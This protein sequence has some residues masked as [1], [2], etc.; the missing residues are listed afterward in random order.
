MKEGYLYVATGEQYID[1]A[2][3]SAKSLRKGNK[4]VSISLITDKATEVAIFDQVVVLDMTVD[5]SLGWKAA[6]L[7]RVKALISSPYEKT[8]FVDSDT[9]FCDECPELFDLLDFYD[10]MACHDFYEAS[11]IQFEG[12]HIKAFP[13][14]NAGVIIYR[15]NDKVIELFKKWIELYGNNLDKYWSDQPAFLDALLC[16]DVK[17]LVL[18][19]IYNFRFKQNV[20]IA[21]GKKVK[22]IHGRLSEAEYELLEKRLN[23]SLEQRAWVGSEWRCFSWENETSLK[24][25]LKKALRK[26][27]YFNK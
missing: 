9:Y 15:K 24:G 27:A 7:Y 26:I 8:V 22:I 17:L 18:Q 25:I 14:M 11:I 6:L 1:E 12:R 4:D 19:S 13:P 20:G 16:S 2:A 21:N 5:E 3:R 23:S 10:V